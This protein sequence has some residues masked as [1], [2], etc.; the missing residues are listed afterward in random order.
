MSEQNI[1]CPGGENSQT[2]T[3]V[4]K[5]YPGVTIS[6]CDTISHVKESL[7]ASGEPHAVP[8][9]NSHQ[10]EILAADFV[11]DLIEEGKIRLADIWGQ[12]I[13]FWLIRRSASP[14]T[15]G[16]IGSVIVAKTQC[17]SF[18]TRTGAELVPEKLT[19]IAHDKFR[20]GAE[21]DGVLVAPGQGENEAGF[22]VT[23][24]QTANPNNFTTFVTLSP[25]HAP[26]P[27]TMGKIW[28]SGVAMRPL[29]DYLGDTEQSFFEEMFGSARELNE[30]PKLIFVF[31]RTAKVGLLFEGA[32]LHAGDLL[33]AEEIESSD[34]SIYEEAGVIA[35]H[36]T[37]EL[38]SLFA[39]EF[40]ALL[41]DDFILHRG[42][43]TCMFAC[44]ILGIF[45]HGYEADTVKPA[46]CFYISKLFELID[47]GARCTTE[48]KQLFERH[49]NV[50]REK[51]SE[52]IT[53]KVIDA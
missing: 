9:W 39:Q 8:I 16:K 47:D 32:R 15:Y 18:L 6:S 29:N 50:W 41:G 3:A 26:L 14:T 24:K 35:R 2:G 40:P 25:A 51:Q 34:I 31:K 44:P 37:E 19:T 23:D 53:F 49:Q 36:Y 1:C 21:W 5:R 42:V 22:V 38:R 33:N 4:R 45:T 52:F 20:E 17:S 7:F 10:G 28:L 48:Q 27:E 12:R 43:N 46:F 13:E 30:I 11:W